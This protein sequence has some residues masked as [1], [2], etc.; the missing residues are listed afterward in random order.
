MLLP[1]GPWVV[2]RKCVMVNDDVNINSERVQC[3]KHEKGYIY[4]FDRMSDG[5][6]QGIVIGKESKWLKVA[7]IASGFLHRKKAHQR[8]AGKTGRQSAR[9]HLVLQQRLEPQPIR[10]AVASC[11]WTIHDIRSRSGRVIFISGEGR[12]RRG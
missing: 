3:S 8:H 11:N 7:N 12:H 4:T 6:D 10:K 5:K 2:W 9:A 1:S